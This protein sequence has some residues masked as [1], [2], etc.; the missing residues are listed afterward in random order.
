MMKI[1]NYKGIKV[2]TRLRFIGMSKRGDY[3]RGYNYEVGHIYKV[4]ELA[5]WGREEI[6]VSTVECLCD[7]YLDAFN[8]INEY[9]C[10]SQC[11]ECKGKCA[12]YEEEV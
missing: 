1:D 2:G 12:F 7:M 3:R 8:I 9:N 10:K 11:A 5:D 4:K 6:V